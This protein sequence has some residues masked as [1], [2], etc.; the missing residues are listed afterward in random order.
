MSEAIVSRSEAI[1]LI[2]PA[3][4]CESVLPSIFADLCL[5][6]LLLQHI[7]S[8]KLK[9]SGSAYLHERCSAV[10]GLHSTQRANASIS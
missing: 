8:C 2:I 9:F 7:S 3:L 4:C 6:D 5:P 10:R 1:A